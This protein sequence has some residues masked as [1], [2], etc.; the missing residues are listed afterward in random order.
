M[1]ILQ[2]PT[3]YA[4]QP[5]LLTSQT[6]IIWLVP[7]SLEIYSKTHLCAKWPFWLPKD[8][9]VNHQIPRCAGIHNFSSFCLGYQHSQESVTVPTHKIR[10]LTIHRQTSM[11]LCIHQ[12]GG[13]E[14]NKVNH[15]HQC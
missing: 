6:F 3:T 4:F 10:L 5:Y 11:P 9:N 14:D 13:E 15:I 2:S 8:A 1:R 12:Q 7:L